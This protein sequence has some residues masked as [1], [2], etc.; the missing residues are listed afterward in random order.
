MRMEGCCP[1][2][3][4]KEKM[5]NRHE[6]KVTFAFA[7][8]VGGFMNDKRGNLEP[9]PHVLLKRCA[10][11]SKISGIESLKNKQ[12]DAYALP[13]FRTILNC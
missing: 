12:I 7:W 4:K 9:R 1:K 6:A 8:R 3:R 10:F 5:A 13:L 11:L 2:E